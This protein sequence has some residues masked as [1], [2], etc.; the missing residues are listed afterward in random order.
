MLIIS[1]TSALS[2]LAETGLLDILP[3]LVGQVTITQA[4]LRE[5]QDAGAPTELRA[6]I[7]ATP[8]WLIVVPDP[9]DF[10]P[11]TGVLGNGEASSITLA[12]QHRQGSQIILDEK[13]GRSIARA[14]GLK[15]TGVLAL[16]ASAAQAG[17][18][19]FEEAIRRLKTADFRIAESL[20]KEARQMAQRAAD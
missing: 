20:I 15:M 18:V 2:A 19:D 9:T 14:L 16:V 4:V 17:W 13:R 7:A 5:C 8:H 1:D 10:L 12:R 3:S 6:W 11:E